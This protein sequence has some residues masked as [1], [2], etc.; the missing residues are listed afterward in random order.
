MA[1]TIIKTVIQL[2]RD[3]AENWL[4]N[5]DVI[6]AAG[7]PCFE[8]DTGVLKIGNGV[9]TYENLLPINGNEGVEFAAD[10]KS[11]ILEEGILKLAGFDAAEIGAQPR[12]NAE[13]IIEWV[14]PST[15]T[16]EGLQTTVAGLQSDVDA[17]QAVLFPTEEDGTE[18]LLARVES[19]ETKM[20]GTGEGTVDAKIDAKINEFAARVTDD[21]TI[22]TIQELITYV[23]NHG[24]EIDTIVADVVTLQNLVGEDS[25]SDQIDA[26]VAA[27]E[28]GDKNVIE[29]ISVGGTILDIVEKGVDIPIA[30]T[31]TLGVVKGSTEINVA[32]DGT[33]SIGAIG[34]D[35]IVQTEGSTLVFDGGSSAAQEI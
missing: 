29:S 7:E 18:P 30:T 21:G 28:I 22:N 27:I 14:V 11:I 12:K 16:T 35:K 17:I 10:G 34:I 23:A 2:R 24:G 15:E 32:E 5:K 31:D 26:A 6:P 3:T 8:L 33:L 25:V 19:L 1:T 13:G 20:D 9:T 4:A